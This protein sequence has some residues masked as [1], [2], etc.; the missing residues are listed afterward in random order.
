LLKDGELVGAIGILR[1]EVR[2]F[3][4][5]QIELVTN[6]AAQAVI[7]VLFEGKRRLSTAHTHLCHWRRPFA[8]LH[9]DAYDVVGYGRLPPRGRRETAWHTEPETR[10]NAAS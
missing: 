4:D 10:E 5:K 2:P 1:E 3:T 8:V 9:N 7:I 6:F